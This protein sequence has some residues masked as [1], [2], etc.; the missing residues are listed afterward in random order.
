MKAN[1]HFLLTLLLLAVSFGLNAA[2][3]SREQAKEK[4]QNFLQKVKG[5]RTLAP[6]QSRAKLGPRRAKSATADS[7]LFYVFNRGEQQGYIIVSGDDRTPEILGYTDNGEFDYDQLPVN[8][9]SWLERREMQL[10]ALSLLPESEA[11]RKAPTHDAISPMVTTQW[12]QGSPYN[13]E[14]PMYF[15]L[16]R[17]VT[18]CVATAMAQVLYFQHVKSVRE[19]Q[20]DMPAYNTRTSHETYGQLHV[21]GIPAGS[22]IDWDNM[23]DKYG[24]GATA[25]QKLAVAQLMHYCGVSVEMDYTNGASGAYSY[26]VADAFKKYFG[27]GSATRYVYDGD[28]TNDQWDNLLYNELYEGRPLYL[29]GANS[30]AGHA[31]VCDGYDGKGCFHIN[32]GWGGS[33]DGYFL[34]TSLNPSS[35]G[36]GGSGDGYSQ[37]EEAIIGCEPDNYWE[38]EMPIAN[39][40]VKRLCLANWDTNGDGKFSFG[41]AAG[42]I[43]LGDVF[44]GQVGIT[45]FAELYNFTSLEHIAD[46]AF[47]GCTKM[48]TIKLPKALKTIGS[49]SFANCKVL[50]TIRLT[51][52]L[53]SIGDSAFAG[54][55][56]M[57][58]QTLPNGLKRIEANT[59][60]G[61]LALTE[62]DLPLGIQFIGKQA[63]SGC[64]KLM[65]VSVKSVMPERIVLGE[66]VFEGID[67]SQATLETLQGTRSYFATADQW[68]EFGNLHENRNLAA[69][70][71][72]TLE[73]NVKYYIYNVG[74]GYFLTHGEAY[75]TQ[76][77]VANTN[78][79]MRFEIRRSTSM[80]A[81]TY[82]LYSNDTP[83]TKHILFRTSTD[84]KVGSGV[85]ACFVDGSLSDAAYWKISL[86]EGEDRVYT[87]QIP[88]GQSGYKANEFLGIQTTHASNAS[89]P[90]YGAYSDI[91]YTDYTQ[92]CHWMLVPYDEAT[93]TLYQRSEE[94]RNL[95]ELGKAKH[96]NTTQEQ[97]VYDNFEST[98]DEIEFSCRRLRKKLS[99]INFKERPIREVCLQYFDVD[100]NNEISYTE[101]AAVTEIDQQFCG[102]TKITDMSDLEYFTGIDYISNK[103]FLNCTALRYV[104][105]PDNA[106]GIFYWAFR[107]A[108]KLERIDIGPNLQTIGVAAFR[109]C[110]SLNE[111]RLAVHDPS[112]IA[113]G[114]SVFYGLN[115]SNAT[116][117]VPQGSKERYAAADVWK[118]F[119]TI[120][121]M[122]AVPEPTF[123]TPEANTD[124]YVYNVGLRS[125]INKGEA[126]GTQ[127]VVATNGLVYQ[128]RRSTS[129]AG[130]TYYLY[131]EQTGLEGKYL[132]RTSTDSKVGAGV[133]ACFVDG[134]SLGASAY[135]KLQP[136]E[137]TENLYTL[138]VPEKDATYVAG[139]YLGTDYGH[140]TN[141]AWGTYGLYWDISY[142][143]NP[144]GCQWGFVSVAAQKQARA[145]FELTE[146]LRKLL[147][148]ADAASLECTQEHNVYDDFDSSEEEI[149]AAIAS[150]RGKLHYIDFADTRVRT[151][152]VNTWDTNED[153]ELSLEEAAAVTDIGTI[154]RSSASLKSF[155]ELRYFTS[156]TNIPDEAFRTCSALTSIYI[157]QQ[158]TS[159]GEKAFYSTSALKYMAVL[160]PTLVEASTASL[161]SKL[162]IFVPASLME[163]YAADATWGQCTIKEY[164]GTPVVTADDASRIYGRS[165]SKFTFELTGAP[166]NGEPSLTCEAETTTPVGTYPILCEAGTV[167]SPGTQFVNGTLTVEGAPLTLTAKSYTR[168]IGEENPEFQFSNSSLKNREKIDDVLITRPV[169]ECDATAD[170]PAGVY[171][172]RISGAEAANYVISYTNGTLTIIDPVG[173]ESIQNSKSKVQNEAIYDLS[174]RKIAESSNCP[175]RKGLYIM[176]KKVVVKD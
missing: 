67:L 80:A 155:E 109:G 30:S 145:F 154:F 25:K 35:Q 56:V 161:P 23:L 133:K 172:I 131:S 107:G 101:A 62:M 113:L 9:R 103:A 94:L 47:A 89:T 157:P 42:V 74:T 168:N 33:S 14:C 26:M 167:T 79:P 160:S 86:V 132:F 63:F 95:L 34:L 163:A 37:G 158:V 111:V 2:P 81:G 3:I 11:P 84:G 143:D 18:G 36:I 66:T 60:E 49:R 169:L 59:F 68:K 127:A 40:T 152:C 119:G 128:L 142:A 19:T 134:K 100:G 72:A 71:F 77:I 123:V 138:Q 108:K 166:I 7:E 137:G 32:W 126:Y 139:E 174:G 24:S 13:D 136:A 91:N 116:L 156:L 17:S 135:W 57:P 104:K 48:T 52:N 88:S 98:Q 12:N 175:I 173:V 44:K 53:L 118:K 38:A 124:Y 6:V 92:N 121:E 151:L 58:N 148:R 76:A 54:C 61:C 78:S 41:E 27:Y 150:V 146:Q 125:Y 115:L 85:K 8:M 65:T 149:A 20:A 105:V 28:Y 82:Y 110:T 16:G 10:E 129:M 97:A 171:E 15:T 165:N 39:A 117:Y 102:N 51:D 176:G 64:T 50:K 22:P 112:Q 114:D 73:T 1:K 164:T 21:D 106:T 90:T 141:A 93:Q 83:N 29:S 120:K 87:L 45:T 162:T 99:F 70:N 4:A 153:D 147:E 96:I 144:T 46:D 170:S 130:G 69:G 122:R 43:D 75:G 5:S 31:F 140:T 159:M 55:R